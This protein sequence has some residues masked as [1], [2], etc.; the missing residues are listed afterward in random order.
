MIS[1]PISEE[2]AKN[3]DLVKF[4]YYIENTAYGAYYWRVGQKGR[5]LFGASDTEKSEIVDANDAG[6]VLGKTYRPSK[7]FSVEK[8]FRLNPDGSIDFFPPM[9]PHKINRKGEFVATAVVNGQEVPVFV[10]ADGEILRLP[11]PEGAISGTATVINDNSDVAGTI[12]YSDITIM[13]TPLLD[14]FGKLYEPKDSPLNKNVLCGWRKGRVVSTETGMYGESILHVTDLDNDGAMVGVSGVGIPPA[15]ALKINLGWRKQLGSPHEYLNPQMTSSD[16][17]QNL[18]H[19]ALSINKYGYVV[20]SHGRVT[21]TRRLVRSYTAEGSAFGYPVLWTPDNR[22]FR[23]REISTD[24]QRNLTDLAAREITDE[25][26]III[27][28]FIDQAPR[29]ILLTPQ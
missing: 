4:G 20:G 2:M 7:G 27:D 26:Q 16:Y 22:M 24:W 15:N 18:P 28:A 8:V 12:R 6:Y 14:P 5:Y 29:T 13:S 11:L 21:V 25:G 1:A 9:Y 10:T 3:P 19:Y 17:E 23:L